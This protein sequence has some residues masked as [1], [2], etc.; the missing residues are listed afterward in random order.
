MMGV[1]SLPRSKD[2]EGF[3]P[4]G[5]GSG[6]PDTQQAMRSTS[7]MVSG[8]TDCNAIGAGAGSAQAASNINGTRSIARIIGSPLRACVPRNYRADTKRGPGNTFGYGAPHVL[9][10]NEHVGRTWRERDGR[11]KESS[12]GAPLL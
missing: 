8:H 3:C 9:A 6:L 4:P 5:K 7:L 2:G 1:P 12:A 11:K 10:R